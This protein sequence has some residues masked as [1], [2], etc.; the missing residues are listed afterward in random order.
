MNIT[1]YQPPNKD[2]YTNQEYL[3]TENVPYKWWVDAHS[4]YIMCYK[5]QMSRDMLTIP[6]SEWTQE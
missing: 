3:E 2:T 4:C 1:Y 6:F 5:I